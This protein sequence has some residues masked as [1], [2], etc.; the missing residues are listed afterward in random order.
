MSL[1]RDNDCTILLFYI[2]FSHEFSTKSMCG[3]QF[4]RNNKQAVF[5]LSKCTKLC[6]LTTEAIKTNRYPW[7]KCVLIMAVQVIKP[8]Q[9]VKH[10][11]WCKDELFE[12]L[13]IYV[14]F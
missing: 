4:I 2:L 6:H 3:N 14:R 8:T 11:V 1:I 9:S 10:L 12:F 5:S 13:R 7:F